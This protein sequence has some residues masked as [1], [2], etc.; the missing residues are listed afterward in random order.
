MD[1]KE[2]SGSDEIFSCVARPYRP[3]SYAD[4]AGIESIIFHKCSDCGDRYF[5]ESSL[6]MHLSRESVL[7]TYFCKIC[8]KNLQY[9]NKCVFL[10]HLREHPVKN[11]D[12]NV[13][14]RPLP[15]FCEDVIPEKTSQVVI[16]IKKN[17]EDVNGETKP[18]KSSTPSSKQGLMSM[19]KVVDPQL[20]MSSGNL[21]LVSTNVK[22]GEVKVIIRPPM[23]SPLVNKSVVCKECGLNY[24]DIRS[25][26]LEDNKPSDTRWK[27]TSCE[28]I[29]PTKC[30]LKAHARIHSK[31]APFVCPDC[32]KE[33]SFF[34]LFMVH[35]KYFCFHLAKCPRFRCQVCPGIFP[36]LTSLEV[37]LAS[38]HVKPVFKCMACPRA[39]FEIK[40]LNEHKLASH[41]GKVPTKFFEQCQLCPQ[42]LLT[43]NCLFLHVHEHVTDKASCLYCYKCTCGFTSESKLDFA[44]HNLSCS[45]S[46]NDVNAV[47][48]AK[49]AKENLSSEAIN[50]NIPK[51]KMPLMVC[52]PNR[53]SPLASSNYTQQQKSTAFT[54][55]KSAN[56]SSMNTLNGKFKSNSVASASSEDK[57][58]VGTNEAIPASINLDPKTLS[59]N[60][61]RK[62]VKSSTSQKVYKACSWHP[63]KCLMCRNELVVGTLRAWKNIP[64]NYEGCHKWRLGSESMSMNVLKPISP[65]LVGRKSLKNNCM[66][67]NGPSFSIAKIKDSGTPSTYLCHICK[68]SIQIDHNIIQKHFRQQH[69]DVEIMSLKPLVRRLDFSK[70]SVPLEL[71]RFSMKASNMLKVMVNKSRT[72][73]GLPNQKKNIPKIGRPK[74]VKNRLNSV[75]IVKVWMKCKD[76]SF[77]TKN[78]KVY[79]RHLNSHKNAGFKCKKCNLEFVSEPSHRIHLIMRHGMKVES[80]LKMD[81]SEG[82][83]NGDCVSGDANPLDTLKCKVCHKSFELLS[84]LQ[85]HFRIHGMAFLLLNKDETVWRKV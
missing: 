72:I 26:F 66:A 27:C 18:S 23:N 47:A 82:G 70:S 3:P 48:L 61:V 44:S 7:I 2:G 78:K 42:K 56:G 16:D 38:K 19:T 64:P 50:E 35:L 13:I 36:S 39:F 22:S 67:L 63:R 32:M 31:K 33:F 77:Q 24:E 71:L 12:L 80:E 21:K 8:G 34:E 10:A 68:H 1:V 37:H 84:D 45:D 25:H 75:E 57:A 6:N 51:S 52:F 29:L 11:K 65:N 4:F 59:M 73:V 43:K 83:A 76:C 17:P 9:K 20:Q 55:V 69:P 5:L 85:K 30:S 53:S 81:G 28:L 46:K 60:T 54:T 58:Q 15:N 40:L 62:Y 14:V 41:G 79:K 49:L 74:L